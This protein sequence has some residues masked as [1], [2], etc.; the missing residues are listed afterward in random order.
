MKDMRGL[1]I[2]LLLLASGSIVAQNTVNQ[3]D[4]QG[5]KQ[6]FWEKKDV[7]GK[8]IYQATFKD[9]K[10]VGEMKRFHPN[11]KIKASLIYSVGSDTSSATLY[12]E[13]GQKIA[14]GKY[15]GQMKTGEWNYFTEGKLVSSETFQYN[16]KNGLAKKY[17]QSGELLEESNWK[18][19]LK[20]G[21]YK[22]FYKNG[23]SYLECMYKLGMLDGWCISFYPNGGMETETF[24][25][26]KLR[27]GDS[28]YYDEEGK[29][30]YMLKYNKGILMNPEVLDSI[31][32]KQ[33]S[34]FEKNKGKVVDP[35]KF[36]AD[37]E[38]Y[39]MKT[40]DK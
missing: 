39:M 25:K 14:Q 15:A 13:K 2:C 23:K 27:E 12:D 38:Q 22:A 16:L 30:C 21:L 20:D 35:E 5:Q 40:R 26:N 19:N 6:G 24:Y 1:I 11:G 31:Q 8:P 33:V 10:P 18:N 29:L 3:V 34:E 17:Y 4:A 9:D 28:K 37:P 7:G 36:M 32:N